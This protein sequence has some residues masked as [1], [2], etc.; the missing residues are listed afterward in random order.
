MARVTDF[1]ASYKSYMAAVK[2]EQAKGAR[3]TA[4]NYSMYR[5]AYE[6]QARLNAITYARRYNPATG[7]YESTGRTM[8][9]NRESIVKQLV[10]QSIDVTARQAQKVRKTII[11][12]QLEEMGL[13][14]A[15]R[16]NAAKIRRMIEAGDID[17]PTIKE[18]QS[19]ERK[20]AFFEVV[21]AVMPYAEDERDAYKAAEEIFYPE[22]AARR[23]MPKAQQQA[24]R[25]AK[26]EA[27]SALAKKRG[28]YNGKP[29][30]AKSIE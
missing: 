29:V 10:H 13:T 28:G 24:E 12:T 30:H 11:D 18:L 1:K 26:R 27:L 15:E 9:Q 19:G 3:V 16:P 22:K 14:G 21:D 25:K 17:A 5:Q 20:N 2:R 23:G 7:T 4:I 8:A 6:T